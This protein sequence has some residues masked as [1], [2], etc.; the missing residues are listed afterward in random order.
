MY[1]FT[2][3]RIS[4]ALVFGPCCLLIRRILRS[5]LNEEIKSP[6]L[7]IL[8]CFNMFRDCF[9]SMAMPVLFQLQPMISA[10]LQPEAAN[11]LQQYLTT[12]GVS[13]S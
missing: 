7:D 6:I 12:A 13:L 4:R 8:R 5:Q 1:P 10:G 11:F 3:E 9:L 2:F